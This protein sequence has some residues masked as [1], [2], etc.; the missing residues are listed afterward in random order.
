MTDF[1]FDAGA[2]LLEIFGM[3]MVLTRAITEADSHSINFDSILSA[4]PATCCW[5][6]SD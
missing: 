4:G 6:I 1:P 5:S 3:K 2:D